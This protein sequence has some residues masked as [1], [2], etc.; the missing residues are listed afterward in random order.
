MS[1]EC[2]DLILKL[3][4]RNPK[5]RLGAGSADAQELKDHEYF[6]DIKWTD[7]QLLKL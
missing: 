7:V 2:K 4:E 6:H 3:L 5:K 1:F